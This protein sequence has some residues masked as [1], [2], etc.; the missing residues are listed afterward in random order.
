ML[1][2]R[3]AGHPLPGEG[4]QEGQV[5][6]VVAFLGLCMMQMSPPVTMNI[7]QE[8]SLLNRGNSCRLAN[9]PGRQRVGLLHPAVLSP[10]LLSSLLTR[11]VW[12][13]QNQGARP[14]ALCFV[15]NLQVLF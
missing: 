3:W 7:H 12:Q 5:A 6:L 2:T 14:R 10:G 9:E 8:L 1:V 15:P 13:R 4:S 11:G